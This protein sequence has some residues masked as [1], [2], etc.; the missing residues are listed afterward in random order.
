M[1][2]VSRHCSYYPREVLAKWGERLDLGVGKRLM[3]GGG[4]KEKEGGEW[5]GW[6]RVHRL[7]SP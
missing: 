4:E 6:E 5:R 3:A 1:N 7:P 2:R